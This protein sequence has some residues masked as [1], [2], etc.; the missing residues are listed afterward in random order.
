MKV[1]G[2][3]IN[4][5]ETVHLHIEMEGNMLMNMHMTRYKAME[6]S[7]GRTVENIEVHGI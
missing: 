5:M 1:S 2:K 3:I 6:L 7:H 4:D